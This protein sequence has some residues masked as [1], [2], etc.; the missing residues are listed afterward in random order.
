MQG[1]D[2]SE[3][4]VGVARG[5]VLLLEGDIGYERLS[6]GPTTYSQYRPAVV[7]G[8]CNPTSS[9]PPTIPPLSLPPFSL[10]PTSPVDTLYSCS[11]PASPT[12][13]SFFLLREVRHLRTV[14]RKA[15]VV[16]PLRWTTR[17]PGESPVADPD[18]RNTPIDD[19]SEAVC[20][21]APPA[22]VRCRPR[23][24]SQNQDADDGRR[25]PRAIGRQQNQP[26]SSDCRRRRRVAAGRRVLPQAKCG[27]R[28]SRTRLDQPGAEDA[29]RRG[30][31]RGQGRATA[32]PAY[33]REPG[34]YGRSEK[35]A[36][37]GKGGADCY[38]E[39]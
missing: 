38:D 24:R 26:E 1:V 10:S 19:S 28:L 17:F 9:L 2:R 20:R 18:L 27:S 6:L 22:V 32:R 4:Q 30:H 37:A 21:P 34:E 15:I 3:P 36:T 16:L 23:A 29:L 5:G 13:V 39:A 35:A 14:A 8:E 7:L 12:R 33:C 11:R 31:R 25:R